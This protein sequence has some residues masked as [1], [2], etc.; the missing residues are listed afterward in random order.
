MNSFERAHLDAGTRA[1]AEVPPFLV[2]SKAAKGRDVVFRG[3]AAPGASHLD[4]SSDLV[5]IWKAA[6]GERFQNY[7]AVFTILDVGTV[8]RAWLSEL[9]SGQKLGP[10]CP[11][12]W[13]R[14]VATGRPR[15]L[16]AEKITPKRTAA[17]QLGR[18]REQGRIVEAIYRHFRTEPI[19]F[20]HFAGYV[21][22]LMDA[23]VVGLDIIR[24]SRDGGRDGVGRYRI[25]QP[26]NCI[27]VDFA[28]EA[29]CLLPP[30]GIGVKVISRLISRLRHRQFGVLVTTSYLADQ[31]YQE[32]IDDQHPIVVCSG[33]DV[34]DLLVSKLGLNTAVEVAT[35]LGTAYPLGS[36]PDPGDAPAGDAT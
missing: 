32:V 34:A 31:A 25:G 23:N 19:A 3:L 27:T 2:F 29:K 36:A 17:Q 30:T 13:R 6:D 8:P 26:Q 14:W 10:N 16:K 20:E 24:P 11:K 35:W 22:Q 1:R 21:V 9:Q 18:T 4:P 5:A 28:M 7:R 33:G 12:V 15:A